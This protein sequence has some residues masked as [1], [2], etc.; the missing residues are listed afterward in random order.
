MSKLP[1][2]ETPEAVQDPLST[3]Y[4]MAVIALPPSD[5]RAETATV[6]LSTPGVAVHCPLVNA[7]GAVAELTGVRAFT[8][9]RRPEPT[10]FFARMRT[11]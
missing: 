6:I 8:S 9:L 2:P 3:R 1:I 10:L 7:E 4:W 11:S 5:G